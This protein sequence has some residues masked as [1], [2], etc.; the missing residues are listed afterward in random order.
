ML[1]WLGARAWNA[2]R[3]VIRGGYPTVVQG[4]YDIMRSVV[5]LTLGRAWIP[6]CTRAHYNCSSFEI[7][8]YLPPELFGI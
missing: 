5:D 6:D 1:T 4:H 7:Q 2:M 3:T 8:L